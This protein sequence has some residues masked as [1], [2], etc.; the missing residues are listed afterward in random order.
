MISMISNEPKEETEKLIKHDYISINADSL[1]DGRENTL[2]TICKF[3]GIAA[4]L[5][6]DS[7]V[8]A[9]RPVAK[10]MI[11]IDSCNLFLKMVLSN[12]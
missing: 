9:H 4:K 5:S 11:Y 2:K 7:N 1:K 8:G 6:G 12:S 10:R 3:K